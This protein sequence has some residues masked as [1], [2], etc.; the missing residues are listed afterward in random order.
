M[1]CPEKPAWECYN[2]GRKGPGK[3]KG[4]HYPTRLQNGV[5][6]GSTSNKEKVIGE[7]K[8][9]DRNAMT[10]IQEH[11]FHKLQR[12]RKVSVKRNTK[13]KKQRKKNEP[14]R[15]MSIRLPKKH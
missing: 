5:A 9:Y 7:K 6:R 13:V 14:S 11:P 2:L 10:Q 4:G 1:V 8:L 3:G 15:G 12:P